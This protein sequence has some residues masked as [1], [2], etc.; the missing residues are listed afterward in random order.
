MEPGIGASMATAGPTRRCGDVLDMR[1]PGAG[2]RGR[3]PD[4]SRR[5]RKRDEEC[6]SCDGHPEPVLFDDFVENA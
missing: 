3:P 4:C 5:T 2:R 6:R 1:A